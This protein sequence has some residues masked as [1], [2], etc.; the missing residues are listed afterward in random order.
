MHLNIAKSVTAKYW[1]QEWITGWY[2]VTEEDRL[3]CT[4]CYIIG[5]KTKL[6]VSM[7]SG[8]HKGSEKLILIS[9]PS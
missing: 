3:Q 2:I 6:E 7:I 8:L 5:S 1:T 4:F 9:K